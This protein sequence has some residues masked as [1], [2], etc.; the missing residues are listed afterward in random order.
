MTL[1][2]MKIKVFSL[3]E[4]YYP[5]LSGLA[6]DEDVLNKINGVVNS[7]QTDLMKYRKLP[8][9]QTITID[10]ENE[11]VIVLS[12]TITDIYQLNKIVLKPSGESTILD[13][14]KEYELI[15]DDTLEVDPG[16]RGDIIVYYY[17]IPAQCQLT[18][19]SDAERDAYDEEFEFDIDTPL[20]EIMPYGIA[21]DL[22][23]LD[24]I[25]SY[26]SYFERTY[27]E[28]KAQIDSR[29]TKGMISFVG[30]IDI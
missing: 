6:E 30:G 9:N 28:L 18:F 8:A 14:Y 22:L 23:R 24:M 13:P 21:R 26:G 3:I 11:N 15:D 4:E 29:R 27:N 20:L 2:E 19:D 17:K 16:F 7:I 5:E 12:E 10:D 1:K 25:S